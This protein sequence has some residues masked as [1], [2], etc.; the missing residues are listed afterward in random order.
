MWRCSKVSLKTSKT[1]KLHFLENISCFNF[2]I[3]SRGKLFSY[4]NYSCEKIW[5]A[6]HFNITVL[7]C[8]ITPI[9]TGGLGKN[10]VVFP[11]M[12]PC[13]LTCTHANFLF[14][15]CCIL[16]Q[17]LLLVNMILFL[18]DTGEGIGRRFDPC[19]YLMLHSLIHTYVV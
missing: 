10:N 19:I 11:N 1:L 14:F 16:Q 7:F 2:K 6:S 18:R 4:K 15:C 13:F 12:Y 9:L 17:Y 3:C 5:A 8:I